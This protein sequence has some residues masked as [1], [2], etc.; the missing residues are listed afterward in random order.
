MDNPMYRL[1]LFAF[2]MLFASNPAIARDQFRIV[3]SST[4]FPFVASAAEEFGNKTNFRTPIVE[5]TGTGGG[6]KL[7]C[8]G[9]GKSHPDIA[10]ASRKIKSSEVKLCAKNGVK[11]VIEVPIG[12]DGIVVAQSHDATKMKLTK[13]QLFLALARDIPSNGKLMKNTFTYWNQIDA[14]L[15]NM[16][17]EVYGPPPTSGTRDAFVELAMEVACDKFPEYKA[18]YPDKKQRHKMC[19]LIREDGRYV[20]TGENDNIIVQKL[21]SNPNSIGIFGFGFLEENATRVRGLKVNNVYPTFENIESGDYGISRSLYIY[22]KKEHLAVA[23][24]I[25]EF[26]DEL[27]SDVAMGED[28]YLP[29]VGLVPMAKNDLLPLREKIL[30]ELQ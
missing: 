25:H 4:V 14:S 2:C 9:V 29:E 1:F 21:T 24:G 11:G 19:H 27:T 8:A 10:N 6:M 30:S 15:P 23:E 26:I 16:P 12:F 5:Q 17:I 13:E 3:G 28:G 20:E 22:V 18:A 7:F